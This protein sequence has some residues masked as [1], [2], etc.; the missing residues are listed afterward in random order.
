MISMFGLSE[1]EQ[2]IAKICQVPII[3]EFLLIA[4][5]RQVPIVKEF[6]PWK[7]TAFF[8]TDPLVGAGFLPGKEV[9]L[10]LTHD[11]RILIDCKTG[12]ELVRDEFS[13]TEKEYDIGELTYKWPERC[14]DKIQIAGIHGGEL[15]QVTSDG[16]QIFYTTVYQPQVDIILEPPKKH[17]WREP[18]ECARINP[19]GLYDLRAF[20]FSYSGKSII[21]LGHDEV[22]MFNRE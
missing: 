17:Y 19:R 15:P 2:I 7:P 6:L 20:G 11:D 3:K 16:W 22:C 21:I 10:V 12:K 1:R 4:K 13:E 8:I 14:E 9:A 5:I 18:K